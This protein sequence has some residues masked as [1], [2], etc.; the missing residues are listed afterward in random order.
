SAGGVPLTA[1]TVSLDS[2]TR[3]TA[4]F[5]LNGIPVGSYS[6]R[7]SLPSGATATRPNA[8]TVEPEGQPNLV[9]R[10]I[11]PPVLGRFN[12]QSTI[13]VEYA[14]TGN[15]AMAAPI[16]T[17][18]SAD[19]DGSDKPLLSLDSR[20]L[21]TAAW[22]NV[23]PPIGF[24]DSV[25]L[26]ANGS[27]PG[28]L[29]PGERIQVPIYFAGLARPWDLTDGIIELEIRISSAN[30]S[31][32][33][34]W[35]V[36][37]PTLRPAWIRDDAWAGVGANLRAQ[38]GS[39][40]GEYIQMLSQNAAYLS[41]LGHTVRDVS[42][43]YGYEVMQAMGLSAI[44]S[45][46]SA[47]DASIPTPGL[48]L[49]FSREFASSI[50]ERH[51]DGPFGRGWFSPWQLYLNVD[52]F[53]IVT[54]TDGSMNQRRFEPDLRNDRRFLSAPEDTGRLTKDANENWVL[55]EAT[56]EKYV[57]RRIGGVSYIEDLNGNRITAEYPSNAPRRLTKL[58]H[59][60]GASLTLDY[61]GGRISRITDSAGRVTT[62]TYDPT[63]TYLLSVSTV[64]G[65]T[66]Y[67][68]D[69]TGSPQTRHALT[70]VTDASG[71]TEAFQYGKRPV[72]WF[73]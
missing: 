45:P 71:V 13:Y 52:A 3:I 46:A 62:Y 5:N 43:L 56:G 25:Q 47:T 53:D 22:S 31:T 49:E 41:R 57:F 63:N 38:I 18:R 50:V 67:T 60:N 21:T 70:S 65:T 66:T 59:S 16:L 1:Q 12:A 11:M 23:T 54:I 6:L 48:A 9:T 4:T 58:T 14:N 64:G 7:V 2:T 26:Y 40:W 37:L 61:T 32:P 73:F 30:D 17:V 33:I 8:F 20:V 35:S 28:V 27:T 10:L 15:A 39:T 42:E 19:P 51:V 36:L 69:T 34:D 68:Y 24:G 72:V 55:T 44:G 29:Q